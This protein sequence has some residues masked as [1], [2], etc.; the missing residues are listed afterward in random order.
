MP[1]VVACHGTRFYGL[2]CWHVGRLFGA[3]GMTDGITGG[4]L[5]GYV[6]YDMTH[7]ALPP[8]R[9]KG[10]YFRKLRRPHM[11]HH[12]KTHNAKYGVSTWFWDDV[13]KTNPAE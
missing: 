3:P 6:I 5:F 8:F 2:F 10:E 9:R 4:F 12:F 11:A 7:Y 13:F 1:P